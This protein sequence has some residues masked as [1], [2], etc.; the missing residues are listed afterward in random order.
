MI[1]KI[2]FSA[3]VYVRGRNIQSI[4]DKF[5]TMPLFH[6]TV[7]KNCEFDDI[8]QVI[9]VDDDSYSDIINEYTYAYGKR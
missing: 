6:P 7:D 4:R 5:E 2:I 1:C 3:S 9:R 8:E